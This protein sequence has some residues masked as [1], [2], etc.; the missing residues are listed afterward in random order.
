VLAA[1]RGTAPDLSALYAPARAGQGADLIYAR[2]CGRALALLQTAP[3]L[4]HRTYNVASGR[5]TT[6]AEILAELARLAP[7][8]PLALPPGRDA[9]AG[10]DVRLD[11]GRLRRDTGYAPAYDTRSA[12]ADYLAWLRAGNA[13]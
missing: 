1:A 9:G 6:N 11:V 2:D 8:T 13:R 4:G 3:E 5:V 12:V 10:P 7:G